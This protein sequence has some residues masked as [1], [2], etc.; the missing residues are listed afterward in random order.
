MR[1]AGEEEPAGGG[2]AKEKRTFPRSRCLRLTYENGVLIRSSSRPCFSFLFPHL[3]PSSRLVSRLVP[4]SC[5]ASR[6]L[7]PACLFI[8]QSSSCLVPCPVPLISSRSFV[9]LCVSFSLGTAWHGWRRAHFYH[10][11]VGFVLMPIH[12][13]KTGG[14]P[15]IS[16]VSKGKQSTQKGLRR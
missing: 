7:P 14:H 13:Y 10:D 15:L 16:W 9:S 12:I 6:S 5:L 1:A 11:C 8:S 2:R 3:V 4:T